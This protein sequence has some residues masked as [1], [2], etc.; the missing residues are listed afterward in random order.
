MSLRLGDKIPNFSADTNEG[1]IDSF[2][3]WIGDSWAVLFSHPADFTPVCTTE[4]ARMAQ[5]M[6]E[7]E[8]RHVKPIAL[9]CDSVDSHRRWIE[10][11][12]SFGSLPK[13]TEPPFSFPII[14]DVERKLAVQF[15]MLDPDEKDAKGLPLTCRA[16]FVIGPEKTLKL[17]ILYPATTGRNFDEIIRVIDS[18]QLT[19]VKKVATPA[20]WKSGGDCMIVP[21][22]SAEE[23][24]QLFPDGF[25][26]IAVPSGKEYIRLTKQPPL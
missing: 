8:K 19:A 16:A 18:L 14:A 10:D 12:K 23:A 2:H 24:K 13:S 6:I 15:G 7:F 9:S 25:K 1:R 4:L 5:L 20:D 17:S 11:I 21:T 3:E 26:T 22:V